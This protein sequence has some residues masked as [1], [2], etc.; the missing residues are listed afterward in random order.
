MEWNLEEALSYYQNMGAP[1]DQTALISLLKEIQKEHGGSIPGYMPS[2]IAERYQIKE[3]FLHAL[4]RRIPTLR[5]DDQNILELCA[6]PNCGKKLRLAAYAEKLRDDSG[7]AFT[8]KFC[9]CMR[10]C[11]KGPNIKWNGKV[12]NMADEALLRQLLREAKID[13]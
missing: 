13:F 10:M 1:R 2:A 4:V 9:P 5:I 12:Y 8:L 11:R 7:N 3:S 6:G